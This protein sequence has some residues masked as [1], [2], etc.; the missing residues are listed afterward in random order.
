MIGNEPKWLR[1]ARELQAL[2]QSGL[3]FTKDHFDR[4]RYEQIRHLAAEMVENYTDEP[5]EKIEGIFAAQ[6]GYATPKVDVRGA[7]FDAQDRILMVREVEDEGR[8]TLPGGWADVNRST[9]ENVVKEVMEESGYEVT[10]TKLAAVW[11]RTKQKHPAGMFS[12]CKMFFLCKITGGSPRLSLETSEIG[13]FAEHELPSD[14]SL[15][16]VLPD[17]IRRMFQHH[18]RP[19]IPT[20]FE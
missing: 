2:A 13:W 15:G 9:A 11:D 3:T 6:S 14:L 1:W 10:V 16:R 5:I 12:C 7:V 17:Q 20:D 4:E 19:E 18:A 8:W